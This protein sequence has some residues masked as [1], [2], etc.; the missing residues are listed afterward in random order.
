MGPA[1]EHREALLS[2]EDFG[3]EKWCWCPRHP[4]RGI[5]R[6]QWKGGSSLACQRILRRRNFPKTLAALRGEGVFPG[7]PRTS[8]DTNVPNPV[9]VS[10]HMCNRGPLPLPQTS[11]SAP[12]KWALV[13]HSP[14]TAK[15]R[16]LLAFSEIPF[17]RQTLRNQSYSVPCCIGT[18]ETGESWRLGTSPFLVNQVL[19]SL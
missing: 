17:P 15:V 7:G 5:P 13:Q 9:A 12:V 11:V 6:E 8:E 16:I 4:D 14:A 19:Y 2:S 3:S 18:S 10:M 1:R